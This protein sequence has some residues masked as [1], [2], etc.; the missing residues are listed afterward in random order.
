MLTTSEGTL[1]AGRVRYVQ[2]VDGYRT[3]I[4]PVLLAASVP[5]RPGECVLEAGTGAGAGLLCLAA[6]IAGLSG[7]GVERDPGMAAL[8]RRNFAANGLDGFSI[9]TADITA[10]APD[11]SAADAAFDHAFANPPW[12]DPAGT[13]SDSALRE[14]AKRSAPGLLAAWVSALAR[15][16]R[17][18]GSLTLILPAPALGEAC[19]AL[20]ASGLGGITLLPLWPRAGR[21]A[22][23]L[24]LRGVRG[25]LGPSRVLPGLVLH[26]DDGY[27]AEAQ[28]ILRDGDALPW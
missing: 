3:G 11:S 5:A 16:L 4:E 8:A 24:L 7:V 15:R 19:T 23:L 20:T 13:A 6:R 26:G 28:A 1:L 21:E 12:H 17:H 9:A 25:G 22:K 18:R 10:F 14:L 27:S 2:P